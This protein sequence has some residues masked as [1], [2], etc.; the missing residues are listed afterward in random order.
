MVEIVFRYD[1]PVLLAGFG[2]DLTY[3]YDFYQAHD[4]KTAGQSPKKWG[5]SR[6]T[7]YYLLFLLSLV[8]E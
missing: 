1:F 3:A 5:S 4:L 7:V 6:S 2:F 8:M